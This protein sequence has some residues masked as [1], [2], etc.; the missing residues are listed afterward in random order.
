M[1]GFV[2]IANHQPQ[3][4]PYL[5]FFYKVARCELLVVM[6]DVQFIERGHQHRNLIKMQTGTQW[7]TV[8]VQRR[9]RQRIEEVVIDAAQNWRRKHWAALQANYGPAPYFRQ[10]E[11]EL[12]AIL[13]EGTQTHLCK[14]DLDLLQ[15]T[16][17]HLAID[18]PMKLSS[19]LCVTGERSERHINIC[20]SVGA[21]TYLSG[22]GGRQYMDL[23]VFERAGI[24]VRFVDFIPRPYPQRF[25]QHGFIPN[26]SVLDALFNCGPADT[27][28]LI[29][30]PT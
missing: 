4:V 17:R 23:E 26:L 24:T 28:A 20:R 19:E 6:D 8:P 22:S 16:M 12:R 5:G 1:A 18:V 3:Y 13:L 25:P 9:H 30:V 15:W 7:L 10:L 2:I 29:D 11:P 27:R 21:D 14:L